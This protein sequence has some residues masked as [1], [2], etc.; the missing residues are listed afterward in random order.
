[1]ESGQELALQADRH[2]YWMSLI[3][4]LADVLDAHGVCA[5]VARSLSEFLSTRVI[6]ALADPSLEQHDIWISYLGK[7]FYQTRWNR[8][9]ELLEYISGKGQPFIIDAMD[10]QLDCFR[11]SELWSFA[12][13]QIVASPIPYPG[14]NDNAKPYGA[15]FIVDPPDV[16]DF[17]LV[18]IGFIASQ[19]SVYLDRAFL[20]QKTDRQEVE[21]GLLS[22]ISNSITSSLDLDDIAAVV[23]DAARRAIGTDQVGIGLLDSSR[24]RLKFVRGIMDPRLQALPDLEVKLG[25][26]IAGWVA[27]HKEPTIVNDVYSDDRFFQE[28]DIVTGFRTDSIL[29]VPLFI[30]DDVI[31][32]LEAVNKTHGT[33]DDN[34]LRLLQAITGPL[35]IAIQNAR[36]HERVIT[37]KRRVEMIFSSMSEGMLT[38]DHH[39]KITATNTSL[40]TLLEYESSDLIG[41]DITEVIKTQLP[42]FSEFVDLVLVNVKQFQQLI[43]DIEQRSGAYVPVI[44]SGAGIRHQGDDVDEMVFVFS[45]LTQIREI[46]RMRDD[47]FNNIV[48]ELHTP[49]ATILMYARLLIQ[50]KADDDKQKASRFLE[51][52]EQES[53]RLQILVRQ[54]L[55]LAKI[56]AT[57]IETIEDSSLPNLVFDQLIPPLS[58]HAVEKG[59]EFNVVLEEDLPPI[60]G[61]EETIYMILKN[62]IENAIK[63]T[64]SGAVSVEAHLEDD[65][66][67]EGGWVSISVKDSGIGIPREGMPNLFSR[68]FRAQTAVE[69]GIAGTG[70]GLYMV[71]EGLDYCGGTIDVTSEPGVGTEFI[72]RIPIA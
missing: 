59:I 41:S 7:D 1:M 26:G 42:G 24:K 50:G 12:S 19:I 64:P 39:G 25:E 14:S 20:R 2:L 38:A 11:S 18:H 17:E 16:M 67:S 55:H 61:D 72:V 51:I 71:K 44:V 4:S 34:D 9:T 29:C 58:A 43:C 68:F 49:L 69:Q 27:L 28:F 53:N 65:A 15:I 40:N 22:D 36:L 66:H 8:C 63:F 48:H 54:M 37:E 46:E 10:D 13:E 21:F 47:F 33:F 30:E 60:Q 35:A 45:D 32:V 23:A 62:L 31:G 52:I 6:V 3:D 70:L 57:E 56:Q 5:A